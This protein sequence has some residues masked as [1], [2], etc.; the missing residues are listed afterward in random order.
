MP[1]PLKAGRNIFC[2]II[3][4]IRSGY[5]QELYLQSSPVIRR[6]DSVLVRRAGVYVLFLT[7]LFWCLVML[8]HIDNSVFYLPDKLVF[9]VLWPDYWLFQNE[10]RL[11]TIFRVVRGDRRFFLLWS[12]AEGWRPKPKKSGL[13]GGDIKLFFWP[14][15]PWWGREQPALLLMLACVSA[16]VVSGLQYLLRHCCQY[17]FRDAAR[18]LLSG[19]I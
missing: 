9:P 17:H 1:P 5:R 18:A 8:F 2:A 13:G 12:V 4:S 11:V 15:V 16:L 3:Y 14:P 7:L 6:A 10:V 19:R